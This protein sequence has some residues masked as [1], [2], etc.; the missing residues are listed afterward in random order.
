MTVN[1]VFV[2]ASCQMTLKW[3]WCFSP[4]R[5]MCVHV[6]WCNDRSIVYIYKCYSKPLKYVSIY[7]LL[8]QLHQRRQMLP[9]VL[10]FHFGDEISPSSTA[11]I[12]TFSITD[13]VRFH[14]STTIHC[15][16]AAHVYATHTL[17]S[18]EDIRKRCR[19]LWT[20][21]LFMR[22]LHHHFR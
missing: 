19:M 21:H 1:T 6:K 12:S 10:V 7:I 3:I 20:V 9:T 5:A 13:E 2:F 4:T 15:S 16:Q 14:G 18:N 11:V 8:A 17:N 22:I